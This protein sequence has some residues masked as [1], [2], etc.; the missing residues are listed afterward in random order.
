MSFRDTGL[1]PDHSECQNIHVYSMHCCRACI[2]RPKRGFYSPGWSEICRTCPARGPERSSTKF[3]RLSLTVSVRGIFFPLSIHVYS[4][5]CCRACIFRP[6]RGFYS[7]GWSEI[8]RTCPARGPERSSTKFTRL[9]LTVSV[10]GIFFPLSI[11]VYSRPKSGF[12]LNKI[13]TDLVQMWP[14]TCGPEAGLI[15][16]PQKWIS[17]HCVRSRARNKMAA[18]DSTT[19]N[20]P[21]LCKIS[22]LD[23]F[24][25]VR[26]N[27]IRF[28]VNE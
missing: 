21:K 19:R 12:G 28:L 27:N 10:R 22:D 25:R 3:T 2:F 4:M 24:I 8:C 6:K 20:R 1:E 17:H 26:D 23:D 5:H 15:L 14:I 13:G 11:H 9:S 7:P 16:G 18:I